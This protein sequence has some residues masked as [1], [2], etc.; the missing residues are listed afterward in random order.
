MIISIFGLRKYIHAD[1]YK[2]IQ[3]EPWT[4]TGLRNF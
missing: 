1:A 4:G 2:M 3:S